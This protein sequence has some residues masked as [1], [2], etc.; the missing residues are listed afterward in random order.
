[1]RKSLLASM[2]GA[3][4]ISITALATPTFAQDVSVIQPQAQVSAPAAPSQTTMTTMTLA[5]GFQVPVSSTPPPLHSAV[6]HGQADYKLAQ[7]L[8]QNG[9]Q[10]REFTRGDNKSW[11]HQQLRQ[12]RSHTMQ[13]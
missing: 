10:L 11:N 8:K 4:V 5:A 2:L 3:I 12:R 6:P 9:K 1:M 13:G 7:K